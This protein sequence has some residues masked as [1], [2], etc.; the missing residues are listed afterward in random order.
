MFNLFLGFSGRLRRREF[1]LWSII[2]PL[3]LIAPPAI[4]VASVSLDRNTGLV[5]DLAASGMLWPFFAL[6]VLAN[7]VSVALFWKR[8]NDVDEARLGKLSQGL[9]RWGYA[10]VTML[11]SIVVGLNLIALGQLEGSAAGFSLIGLWGMACRLGPHIGPN[12][13]G[14]D[15]RAASRAAGLDDMSESALNLDAAMQRALEGRAAQAT[16]VLSPK[17]ARPAA[18]MLASPGTRPSFGKRG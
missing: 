18:T 3:T 16:S 10:G 12:R 4:A 7:Y 11:N 14:P 2:V 17:L 9:M 13:S 5:E 8:I 1:I 15:P 6:L